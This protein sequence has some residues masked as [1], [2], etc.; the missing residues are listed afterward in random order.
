MKC[1]SWDEINGL[2]ALL[3]NRVQDKQIDSIVGISRSG[4]I[5]AV[6]LSNTLG[7]RNFAVLDII[8][9]TSDSINADKTGANYRS[10]LNKHFITGKNIL[11]V[12]DIVGEGMTMR[13]ACKLLKEMDA[14]V[15]ST[16]LVVNQANL[17]SIVP[18]TVVD[19]YGCLVH[20]WV[21]FPWEGKDKD[22]A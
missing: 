10:I 2:V 13:T 19:Y 1:I 9:I 22:H 5:P 15:I 7:V 3:A 17:G 11:L 16:T 6:M 8:R 21:I 12:D 18:E 4:L 14:N 20:G